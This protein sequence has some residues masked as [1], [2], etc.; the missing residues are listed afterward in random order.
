MSPDRVD[1]RESVFDYPHDEAAE[2]QLDD[3]HAIDQ[4]RA[5]FPFRSRLSR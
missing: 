2:I 1:F 4:R 3:G 5:A